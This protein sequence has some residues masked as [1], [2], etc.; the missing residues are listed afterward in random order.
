MALGGWRRGG[1][2]LVASLVVI[3]AFIGLYLS[4]YALGP[5]HRWRKTVDDAAAGA[6]DSDQ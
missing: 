3:G 5:D 2:L 6:A 4:G 1:V